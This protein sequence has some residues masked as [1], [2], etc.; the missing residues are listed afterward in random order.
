M[1]NPQDLMLICYL[2]CKSRYNL[3]N[4]LLQ[5][6]VK[7]KLTILFFLFFYLSRD[8]RSH[9]K[10]KGAEKYYVAT[11]QSALDFID[12]IDAKKLRIDENIFDDLY[13]KNYQKFKDLGYLHDFER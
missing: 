8:F 2:H 9:W 5:N 13:H 1:Q 10:L 6:V 7:M 11:Y 4:T 12:N 3:E